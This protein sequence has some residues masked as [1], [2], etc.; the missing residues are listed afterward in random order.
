MINKVVLKYFIIKNILL[1]RWCRTVSLGSRLRVRGPLKLD[2]SSGASLN[3]GDDFNLSSGL[4]QNPLGRNLK[5]MIRIEKGANITIGNNVGMT[6][7]TLW[8]KRSIRIGDNVKLGSGVII[9]DSD[10]HA[11]DYM[12][13]RI[14]ERD[15]INASS[16]EIVIGDDVFIGVNSILTKGVTIG[17]RSI[18][19]AGSVVVKSILKD[20]IWGGNP[21]IFIKKTK[22]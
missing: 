19:A 6:C 14:P 16:K 9:L 11:L 20:E 17:D 5:S 15:S 18:V 10:M 13:R 3:I 1:F 7:V 21:A 8:S 2:I 4:M 12:K 22:V